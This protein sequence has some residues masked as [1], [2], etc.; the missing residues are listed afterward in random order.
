MKTIYT[1]FDDKKTGLPVLTYTE[2]DDAEFAA[3]NAE[4][5]GVYFSANQF[6]NGRRTKANLAKIR[7]AYAD[8][9]VAK[10][11]DKLSRD[12]IEARKAGL[13]QAVIE[14]CLPTFI[15]DTSN[16]LQPCWELEDTDPLNAD[17]YVN[18]LKGIVAWSKEHGSAGDN[19]YDVARVLRLPNFNHMK[20]EPYMCSTF[21]ATTKKYSYEEL[22]EKFPYTQTVVTEQPPIASQQSFDKD[23][24][25]LAID[26]LD[27]KE[28]FIAAQAATG[29]TAT[30][31]DNDEVVLDGRKTGTFQ[32]REGDRQY[33]ATSSHEPFEGNKITVVADIIGITNK[34]A[35][36]W[37]MKT[38]NIDYTEL[39]EKK[40]VEEQLKEIDSKPE[41]AI[42]VKEKR[43]TWGTR[44]LDTHFAII[45]DT[46][47]IVMAAKRSS[48]KT[49][50]SVDMA[51]KNACERLHRT[52]YISLEMETKDILDDFGRKYAG[53][54]VEE[55]FD[56]KIPDRKQKAYQKRINYLSNIPTLLL[57]GI[58]RN[59]GIGWETIEALI[60]KTK[61]VDIVFIDNLDLIV[62]VTGESDIERQKRITRSM[63]A[64]SSEYHIPIIL[65][66]HYRKTGKDSAGM[67]ELA[68]SG[69]IADNADRIVT[70][71]R[72][73]SWDD[74][75]PEKY[76]STIEL[77]KG[78]GYPEHST[79]VYFIKGT[80]V[81]EP[82]YESE[83]QSEHL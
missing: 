20:Q 76:R 43:F 64:F 81:D 35:R 10:D 12:E 22:E 8:F 55:E 15:I 7:Y 60:H 47:F 32:G 49:V 41:P 68:G 53:I 11:G 2:R 39:V 58:R 24:V 34:E 52:M 82:P 37:I 73:G 38:F 30:F 9:D 6:D 31:N 57:T 79:E 69:K 29:R 45:K 36:Q 70:I 5:Y 61:D 33:I 3:R 56:N 13:F 40:K 16:G 62:G 65:I 17:R 51:T 83:M 46:N 54:T 77:L 66:H 18:I 28:V 50:F 63:M 21:G 44:H 4:G 1:L 27:I 71:T 80:F 74:D 19:V 25:S 42:I 75:Y 78:R 48:G 14:Y 59:N 67:D 23:E 72:K 26:V